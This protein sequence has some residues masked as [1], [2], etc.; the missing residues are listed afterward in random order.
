MSA[1]QLWTLGI[2]M[3]AIIVCCGLAYAVGY[4]SASSVSYYAGPIG[5]LDPP[6]MFSTVAAPD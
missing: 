4:G 6:R 3:G 1:L 5:K 2:G